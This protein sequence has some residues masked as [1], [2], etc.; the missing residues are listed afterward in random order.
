[1]FYYMIQHILDEVKGES[2]TI[3]NGYRAA[4]LPLYMLEIGA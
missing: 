2:F 3:V 4:G 1:M